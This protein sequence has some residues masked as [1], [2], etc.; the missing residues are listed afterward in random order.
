M[1]SILGA[2]SRLITDEFVISSVIS[3]GIV[4]RAEVRASMMTALYYSFAAELPS[5]RA[6]FE[7]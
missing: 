4:T 2:V 7:D 6:D 3:H 5:F 1:N